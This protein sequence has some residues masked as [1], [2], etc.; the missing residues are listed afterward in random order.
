VVLS[1]QRLT[2]SSPSFFTIRATDGGGKSSELSVNITFRRYATSAQPVFQ[3]LV[4]SIRLSEGKAV[5]S[6]VLRFTATPSVPGNTILYS[7][8]GGNT[9]NTFMVGVDG[10]LILTR[11]LD[12]SLTPAF[13]LWIEARDASTEAKSYEK[14]VIMIADENNHTPE[15][16]QALY[17]VSVVEEEN[18]FDAG[19]LLKVTATDR[20]SGLNGTVTYSLL[21][22]NVDDPFILEPD[23][24]LVRTKR[25]DRERIAR[26][27]LL[28]Q[29]RDGGGLTSTT[30]VIVNVEDINDMFP[31][32]DSAYRWSVA[33]DMP[34]GSI[35]SSVSA[36][37]AD[38]GI[39]AEILYSMHSP[40]S[41]FAITPSGNVTLT[42]KLDR[43]NVS[44][45]EVV[46]SAK[47]V[48]G[49]NG[50]SGSTTIQIQ[51]LCSLLSC[52]ILY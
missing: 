23:G 48:E 35:I 34:V 32:F 47:N 29:A 1:A 2:S 51:V 22:G 50:I 10:Q 24:S 31:R 43:E 3:D 18:V 26:Y 52:F 6:Q 33:E 13:D 49:E 16:E 36:T 37:D 30:I 17:M 20:D 41:H 46:V 11:A 40:S 44:S 5:N 38:V 14:V 27:S 42:A 15:F 9:A 39:N 7:I 28:I 21:S 4:S 12:Y 8:A 45:Y 25:L 19:L